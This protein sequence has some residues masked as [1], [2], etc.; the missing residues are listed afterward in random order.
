MQ[1]D[2]ERYDLL[3]DF[4]DG[5]FGTD[6]DIEVTRLESCNT[7]SGSG[8]KPGTTPSSCKTC[9]GQGQVVTT[10]QTPLG[11][12]RQVSNCFL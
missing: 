2:D 7:C 5:V 10:A 12:F 6:K 9:G 3:L 8:A 11:D 1:G 4:K